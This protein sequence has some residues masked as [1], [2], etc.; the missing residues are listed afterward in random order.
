[1]KWKSANPDRYEL[2]KSF[3]KENRKYMTDAERLL[4]SYLKGGSFGH[5][6]LR[7][8]IIGDYIVDFLCRDAQVVI[9]VDGGYHNPS[10]A[11]MKNNAP[12]ESLT[13]DIVLDFPKKDETFWQNNSNQVEEDEIRQKWLESVGYKV[14]RFTNEQ[15]LYDTTNII[16]V[17]KKTIDERLSP[18]LRSVR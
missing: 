6:F 3:A 5:K 12:L 15:V 16:S 9:E 7:Q 17:I 11:K 18:E 8:H 14:I 4:W 13:G 1:M 10:N 2:L